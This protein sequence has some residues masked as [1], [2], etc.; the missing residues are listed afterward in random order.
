MSY[1]LL[2]SNGIFVT[3]ASMRRF[4]FILLVAAATFFFSAFKHPIYLSVTDLKYTAHEKTI[5]GSV[6]IFVNDF[7]T[8]LKRIHHKPVDL[9]NI[10]DSVLVRDVCEQYLHKNLVI[11][12]NGKQLKY[13]ILGFEQN[14]EA[15]WMYVESAKSAFPGKVMI[16]NTILYQDFPQQMNI[17]HLDVNKN[18]KSTRLINPESQAAFIF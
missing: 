10:K 9:I 12:V 3:F 7:E 17:I 6:K 5:Q 18:Q 8:A 1:L 16:Q 11:S 4:T 13:S 14:E 2:C 15:F